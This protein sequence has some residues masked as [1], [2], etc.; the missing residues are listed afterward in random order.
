[1]VPGQ[2]Y[3]RGDTCCQGLCLRSLRAAVV[4]GRLGEV[5][6]GVLGGTA[7]LGT[8]ELLNTLLP[9]SPVQ[10]PGTFRREMFRCEA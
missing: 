7:A 1:M 2:G 4:L 10:S 9:V 6:P 8:G 5:T 3:V